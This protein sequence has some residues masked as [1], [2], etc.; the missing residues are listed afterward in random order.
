[1]H[2]GREGRLG[3][4]LTRVHGV[5]RAAAEHRGALRARAAIGE[6]V[7][8]SLAQ[9]GID[10]ARAVMLRVADDA[11]A[12]LAAMCNTQELRRA[13]RQAP[14]HD[15]AALPD[16]DGWL[17]RDTSRLIARYRTG[18]LPDPDPARASLAELFAWCIA[19]HDGV[20]ATPGSPPEPNPTHNPTLNQRGQLCC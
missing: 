18:E 9:L 6:A 15:G 17:D 4:A 11:A 16:D 7:R 13:D 14:Q 20:G 19:R 8:W 1:M 5:D 3:R 12:E 2:R 10:P